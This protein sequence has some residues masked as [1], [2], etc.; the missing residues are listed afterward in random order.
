MPGVSMTV[1]PFQSNSLVWSVVMPA[2]MAMSSLP[3]RALIIVDFPALYWPAKARLMASLLSESGRF[4]PMLWT[5]LSRDASNA[6]RASWSTRSVSSAQ[7][8]V[9]SLGMV[10][11]PSAR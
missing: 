9:S 2:P 5:S 10:G 1:T 6:S 8:W 11:S 7:W 4:R 3:V